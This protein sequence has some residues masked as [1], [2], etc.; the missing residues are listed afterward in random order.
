MGRGLNKV[1]AGHY[2]SKDLRYRLPYQGDRVGRHY[3]VMFRPFAK[4]YRINVFRIKLFPRTKRSN[5]SFQHFRNKRGSNIYS[6]HKTLVSEFTCFQYYQFHLNFRLWLFSH[7]QICSVDIYYYLLLL[8]IDT[9][10]TFCTQKIFN[11]P[12]KAN[13]CLSS[14]F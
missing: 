6:A 8:L 1:G 12:L 13:T 3:I 14:R 2:S 10:K 5:D 9:N 11:T 4:G 7:L